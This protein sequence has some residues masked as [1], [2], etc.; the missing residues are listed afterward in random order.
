M[1]PTEP[2][3][4]AVANTSGQLTT[5]DNRLS[6]DIWFH[7]FSAFFAVNASLCKQSDATKAQINVGNMSH[8][9][10]YI[11]LCFLLVYFSHN[12]HRVNGVWPLPQ[13]IE[14]SAERYKMSPRLF[15]F[16]YGNDSAAQT[17]CS[18]LDA[19]FK[20]YFSI[21]FPDFTE[22]SGRRMIENE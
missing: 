3:S 13:Q 1:T 16:I 18:V 8:T 17:G 22:A 14:E 5:T 20:R 10:T 6:Y 7:R 19:A 9:R 11:Q 4:I 2:M 21:I 15:S 12:V